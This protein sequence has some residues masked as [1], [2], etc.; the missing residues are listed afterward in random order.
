[1]RRPKHEPL[2]EGPPLH[3]EV[4]GNATRHLA[5]FVL[6]ERMDRLQ[7]VLARRTRSLTALIEG[8]HDPHNV[9]ACM[10][11]CDAFG[12]QHLHLVP[13]RGRPQRISRDV[14]RGADRWITLHYHATT[15]DA[16]AA[17]RADGYRIV[18][19]DLGGEPPPT[20]LHRLPVDAPLCVA[21]GNEHEGISPTLRALAD[22]RMAIPMAGF[23]ESLNISVAFAIA[24]SH[25]RARL[26]DLRGPDG[27]L[28]PDERAAVLDRWIVGDVPRAARVLEELSRRASLP[29]PRGD[30]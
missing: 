13:P 17:L 9:A 30:G 21:F 15:E 18:A 10:R 6:P 16:V 22:G 14:S 1:M 5:A 29:A 24:L 20:P 26:D 28:A 2:P 3:L 23:V 12:V 7:E 27:D 8:V 19:T 25:L 11:T 4:P